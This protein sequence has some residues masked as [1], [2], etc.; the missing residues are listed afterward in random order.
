MLFFLVLKVFPKSDGYNLQFGYTQFKIH[1]TKF[2][3]SLET[4]KQI[5]FKCQTMPNNVNLMGR[6]VGLGS[7]RY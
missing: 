1:T 4:R 7:G 3:L 6:F 5:V 2:N